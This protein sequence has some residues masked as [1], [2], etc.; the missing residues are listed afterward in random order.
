MIGN[1]MHYYMKGSNYKSLVNGT[2]SQWEIYVNKK[3]YVKTLT[4]DSALW[5]DVTTNHDTIY[6]TEL[7]KSDTTILGYNCDKLTFVCNSG[8]QIYYFNS[9]FYV[10]PL[11]Y[12]DHKEGNWYAYLEQA[13]AIALK[14]V[15]QRKYYIF[16]ITA[17]SVE[18]KNLEDKI[19]LLPPN[20]PTVK[21]L[22]NL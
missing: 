13:K 9:K 11:L 17:T 5:H 4:K 6:K 15:I 8:I 14:E 20:L 1:E 10:D 2:V 16:I 18:Q 22:Y 3:V 19:F 21:S 12:I 7:K